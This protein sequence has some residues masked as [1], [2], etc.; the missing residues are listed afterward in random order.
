MDSSAYLT[1]IDQAL[2]EALQSYAPL[3]PPDLITIGK[4]ALSA[5]GKVMSAAQALAEGEQ[6]DGPPPKWPMYAILAYQAAAEPAQRHSW[7]EALPAA[8]AVEIAMAAADLL[9]E[10]TD[11]D[12][13]PVVSR[14]GPGQ[15][16][17]TAN[18]ML[19]MAQQTLVRKAQELHE[20]GRTLAALGALQDMLVEAAI[21]QHLDMAYE[22]MGATEVTP[23]MSARMTSMKAGAL[24]GGTFRMGAIM[25]GADRPLVELTARFGR[26]IGDIAQILNDIQD[27][28]PY[29]TE[30]PEGG[31][32]G[33]Y[34]Q[35]TDLRQM[36]RTLPI[37]FTL[38]DDA[39]PNALQLAFA[40][41]ALREDEPALRRAVLA[42]GGVQFAQLVLDI[43]RN[44]ALQV[45]RD[46]E[47]SR[48]GSRALL[49]PLLIGEQ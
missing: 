4:L 19:V 20:A 31:S 5:P 38:R 18:L 36:K 7:P 30:W 47:E 6:P 8:I 48:P 40:D 15:A 17:N 3:M 41:P 33:P 46:L 22:K 29:E 24:I 44:N 25:S 9:D 16:L 23:E 32:T 14:Y 12:P 39:E 28:L 26:E 35:K 1:A 11:S 34:I 42:A 27:V 21:G 43:H 49:S 37:V 13:S 10:I 2:K 45:L